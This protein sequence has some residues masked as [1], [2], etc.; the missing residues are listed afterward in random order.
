[1]QPRK[2]SRRR[3]DGRHRQF[4]ARSI[5]VQLLCLGIIGEYLGRVYEEVKGRRIFTL[6]EVSGD[7]PVALSQADPVTFAQRDRA[8][9]SP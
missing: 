4:D 6:K 7:I 5:T 8:F 2:L 3:A 1:M 9:P